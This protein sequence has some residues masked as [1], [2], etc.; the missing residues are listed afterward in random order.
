MFQAHHFEASSFELIHD[1]SSANKDTESA[2]VEL[3]GAGEPAA[4][5][6][7]TA[8]VNTAELGESKFILCVNSGDT[9]VSMLI[10]CGI[11]RGNAYSAIKALSKKFNV[12]LL[13]IGQ[14]IHLVTKRAIPENKAYIVSIELKTSVETTLCLSGSADNKFIVTQKKLALTRRVKHITGRINTTFYSAVRSEGVPAR[15]AR[16]AAAALKS[17][18]NLRHAKPGDKFELIYA[19]KTNEAGEVIK[20]EGLDYVAFAPGGKLSRMYRFKPKGSPEGFY[21]YKGQALSAATM[22]IPLKVRYRISSRFGYRRDPFV[23]SVRKFHSGV[24]LAAPRGTPIYAAASGVVKT[25]SW[26]GGYGKFVKI[27]HNSNIATAYGHMSKILVK[28]GQFVKKGQLIGKVGSTGRS[29]S[30]HLHFEVRKRGKRVNP[31][32]NVSFPVKQ[33]KGPDKKRFDLLKTAIMKRSEG[34]PSRSEVVTAAAP[35]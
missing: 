4:R 11:S 34:I 30:P 22:C 25:A 15:I 23:R 5:P 7:N 32:K 27:A 2:P 19:V 21:N 10:N 24:D 20:V 3:K 28:K 18:V 6:T 33:L 31:L 17:E 14:E 1:D 35:S 13:K 16:Q 26:H 12:R 9:L 29:T 8:E